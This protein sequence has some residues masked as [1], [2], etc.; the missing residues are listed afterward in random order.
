MV[1]LDGR[2][3]AQ[4]CEAILLADCTS[5]WLC[6]AGLDWRARRDLV[7][8]LSALKKRVSMLVISHD[9][10]ELAPI[11]DDAWEMHE[12]GRLEH[13]GRNVPLPNSLSAAMQAL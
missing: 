12:G 9:L 1:F 11:V 4:V 2:C 7:K 10:R 13:K 5:H 3:A 6:H 8:L